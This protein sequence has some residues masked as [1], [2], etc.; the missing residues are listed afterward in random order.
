MW[1]LL[2]TKNYFEKQIYWID[3]YFVNVRRLFS[4]D[5]NERFIVYDHSTNYCN[6]KD[7]EKMRKFNAIRQMNDALNTQNDSNLL[8]YNLSLNSLML[9]F[10]ED[11][12]INQSKS[13]QESFKMLNI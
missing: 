4:N 9:I 12:D 10:R 6:E 3:F 1:L 11:K 7:Y 2:F 8:I 13:W 5:R